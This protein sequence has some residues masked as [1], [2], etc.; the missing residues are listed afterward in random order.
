[1]VFASFVGAHGI[2]PICHRIN[3]ISNRR[4]ICIIG[5]I[6]GV[7]NTPLR[8]RNLLINRI[9]AWYVCKL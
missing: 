2:R 5:A 3:R 4:F 9:L 6:Q 7:C 8:R 1:M